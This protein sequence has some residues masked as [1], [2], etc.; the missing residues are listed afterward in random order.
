MLHQDKSR[1]PILG[2][3]GV[4]QNRQT[5]YGKVVN[6]EDPVAN[7]LSG[8]LPDTVRNVRP[9]RYFFRIRSDTSSYIS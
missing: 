9:I 2:L 6:Y 3:A 5:V 7:A 4:S 1:K 8:T